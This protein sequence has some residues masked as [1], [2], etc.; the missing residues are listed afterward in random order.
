MKRRISYLA[1]GLLVW[2]QLA[3]SPSPVSAAT[4]MIFCNGN[5]GSAS[6][7][8]AS[9]INGFRTSGF[10]TIVLFAMSVST[11][12]DFTYGGQTICSNG[13]YVGPS[14]WGSLLS[15]CLTAPSSVTRIEM[16]LGGAGDTSW[17]NI[18]S[19]IAATGTNSGTVLYQN[20]SA[21]K[22]ALGINAIDSDDESSYDS[23]SAISFGQMCS[24][25]GMKMTLCPYTD[26]GYW[27]AVKSGLGSEV[28]YIYLQCYSGGAGNDPATW[29]SSMGV[30][31]SQIV[32]GYWDYERNATFLTNM[33]TWASEGCTGGFLWPS[34]TGCNPPAGP[35]EMLQYAGWIWTVFYPETTNAYDVAANSAYTGDG[36]PNGLSPGGQKGG[37]GFGAWT[38]YVQ[39]TGGAFI[40]TNGPSGD[41]FDLWNTS[42]NL[43]TVAVRPLNSPLTV[44]Q[45]FTVSIRLNSLDTI[46]NTNEFALEDSSGN[47]LFGYWHYGFEANANCG[48]Y[49]DATTNDGVAVN[50]QYAYQQFESFTFTLD[51]PTTYTFIDN[52][53]GAS[54]S[55]TIA[56]ARIAQVA[57]IRVNGADAPVNGQDFQFD[58]L[59]ITSSP[60]PTF[61]VTPAQGSLSVPVTNS[62]VVQVVAGR[63]DSNTSVASMTVDGSSVTP[64]VGGSS[65]LMTVSY[66]PSPPLSAGSLHTVQLAVQDDNEVS[67]TNTWSFTTGFSSLPAVLPGPFTVSN[68]MDLTTFTAAGDPWLSTNY[69]SPSSQTLYV[70][71]SMDIDTTNNTSSIYTWGGMDFF[72]GSDE[73]LL[74]GKNGGSPH[75]S[76]AI[77]GANGPDLNPIVTVVPNEWRTIVVEVNYQDGAPANESVW[78]D[79]DF[80][81]TEA[82]QPQAPITL[83]D[84]NTF[85]NIRLRCGFNDASATFSN[86]VMAATSAQVGFQPALAPRIMDINLSGTSLS[87]SATNGAA[88][89]SWSLLQSTN[90]MLPLSQWQTNCT[91]NF[92]R[93]G[94]LSANITNTATNNQEFFILKVR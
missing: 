72:Q 16:C 36:P 39:N 59:Q 70:R 32:P 5:M 30:Q 10:T 68:S 62:I 33:M 75:W 23:G 79:P 27:A 50:F 14:N 52:S 21:L 37:F 35:G 1:V 88:D 45:S 31:V 19:L 83:S 86:I 17:A 57:F 4:A 22:N 40:Q 6:G 46:A 25:V 89:G 91:G 82:N 12:G 2:L 74:F 71:F 11:N 84:D 53:T 54:F 24:A 44:G 67:Y 7:L 29:A 80:T 63:V 85:D 49:S 69:L 76:I 92:D 94:N 47:I 42:A 77:D 9:Q 55:G 56:N 87:I 90:L 20:L 43:S 81:Q 65:S 38:F 73:K 8:T 15:Q 13:V 41:S 60:P 61:S 28:D 58:Q 64:T 3:I 78:L 51:S 34:C 48:W 93:S 18:K 26:S 66:T